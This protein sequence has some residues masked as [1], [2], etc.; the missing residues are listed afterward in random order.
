MKTILVLAGGTETDQAVFHA[1]LAAATPVSAH[2]EFLHIYVSPGQ[3][4][5]F[6]P[7]VDY[8]R[9]AAL[10]DA[11]ESLRRKAEKRSRDANLHFQSFCARRKIP[12]VEG[13]SSSP[14]VSATFREKTDEVVEQMLFFARRNDLIVVSRP[15]DGN[16]IPADFVERILIESGRPLLLAPARPVETVTGTVM[17]CW[18]ETAV[19][20]RALASAMPLL[21]RSRRVMIVGITEDAGGSYEGL[22]ELAEHLRWHGI[23]SDFRWLPSSKDTVGDQL[24]AVAQECRADLI[25]MGA[26]GHSRAREMFFGGCTQRFLDQSERPV[27]MVH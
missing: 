14:G 24:E 11:L 17:V 26:Y 9:G 16:G 4:A 8:A 15:S 12:I 18:K 19:S 5:A 13:P 20:A 10:S 25:V 27:F 7:H 22:R 3:A 1:A 23:S 2:L 6:T 21:A